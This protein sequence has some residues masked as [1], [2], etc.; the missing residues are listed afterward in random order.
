MIR[1]VPPEKRINYQQ[2][3]P[4]L[5]LSVGLIVNMMTNKDCSA[6]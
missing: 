6:H 5:G 3:A 1:A 4:S 2:A